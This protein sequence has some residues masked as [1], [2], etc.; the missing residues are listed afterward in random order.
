VTAHRRVALV[1]APYD[2]A[3]SFRRGAARAPARIRE[4]L[5]SPAGNEWSETG[6]SMSQALADRGDLAVD[7]DVNERIERGIAEILTAGERPLMLGGD[8]AVS[9]GAVHA[10]ARRYERLTVVQL[11]AHPDLYDEFEG[12]RFSHA[13][14]F[15]RIAEEGVGR[16]VQVGIRAA[17]AHQLEQAARFGVDM[18]DMRR[19]LRGDRPDVA[20]PVYLSLDLDVIDPA[21]APGVSHP[22]PGGLSV[23]EVIALV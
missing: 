15:A 3:S 2:A 22:E 4:L 6:I 9:Y 16:I 21:H 12:N 18:I 1:G 7:G 5:R 10:V 20:A 13:C 19:W 17:N 8:H 23:R 14:T 11:D